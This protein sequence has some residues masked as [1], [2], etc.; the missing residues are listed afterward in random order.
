[1]RA[2]R[3]AYPLLALGVT[4]FAISQGCFNPEFGSPGYYCHSGDTPACPEGQTCNASGRCVGGSGGDGGTTTGGLIPKTGSYTGAKVDPGLTDENQC[5]DAA[6]EGNDSRETAVPFPQVSVDGSPVKL[7]M[8]AICPTGDNP[9]AAGHDVD[10]FKI[11]APQS[12][13]A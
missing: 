4:L 3:L 7:G 6:L 2:L 13:S 1:M 8:L 10:Y 12:L 11:T 9:K 5:T